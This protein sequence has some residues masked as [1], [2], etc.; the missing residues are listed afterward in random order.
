MTIYFSE[1][2]TGRGGGRFY[3]AVQNPNGSWTGY[4]S[5]DM[6]IS[7]NKVTVDFTGSLRARRGL[8]ASAAY[9]T[10]PADATANNLRDLAGNAVR[11]PYDWPGGWWGTWCLALHN[12]TRRPDVIRVVISSDAGAERYYVEGETIRVTLTYTE[13]VDVT[14]APRLKIKIDPD[15][16]EFAANYERGTGTD[17]LIFAYQVAE[18]NTSPR[19]IAVLEDSLELNGGRSARGLIRPAHLAHAGLSHDPNHKVDW[20]H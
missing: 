20:Q 18:P 17:T 9:L 12:P 16:G 10:D 3:S 4:Y 7:G 11:T 2:L 6:E 13:A 5:T 14:G 1:P 8:W 19:G 15:W